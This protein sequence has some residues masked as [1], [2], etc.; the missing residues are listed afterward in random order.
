M[1]L[2]D[3][4]LKAVDGVEWRF[5]YTVNSVYLAS[6]TSGSFSLCSPHITHDIQA[7]QIN[8][9]V[10]FATAYVVFPATELKKFR[11]F[12]QQIKAARL[13]A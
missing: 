4:H 11:L 7:G 9:S 12:L 2:V 10:Y 8:F 3:V 5:A 1:S 13:V 6:I